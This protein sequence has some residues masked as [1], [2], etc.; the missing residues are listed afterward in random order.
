M[1]KIIIGSVLTL[2]CGLANAGVWT[3]EVQEASYLAPNYPASVQVTSTMNLPAVGTQHG[4]P[5]SSA[6]VVG[7][8]CQNPV[9]AN[10]NTLVQRQHLFYKITWAPVTSPILARRGVMRFYRQ[11][12]V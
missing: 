4:H 7:A 2:M 5:N 8:W 10:G 1:K 3:T 9:D 11:T 12:C 6:Q